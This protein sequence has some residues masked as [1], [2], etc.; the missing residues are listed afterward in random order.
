MDSPPLINTI[1]CFACRPRFSI[2]QHC[3]DWIVDFSMLRLTEILEVVSLRLYY[4]TGTYHPKSSHLT[5]SSPH[6]THIVATYH[7]HHCHISHTSSPHI[8]HIIA[9]YHSYHSPYYTHRHHISHTSSP[10]I[11]HIVATYHTHRRH[12]SHTSSLHITHIVATYH[13]HRHYI[14]HTSSPH[15]TH[16]VTTYHTHHHYQYNQQQ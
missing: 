16:I 8:T 6:I 7:T 4:Q 5:T 14:S 10:H 12:I 1:F 2:F 15:I 11:T 3:R 13:T 9:T